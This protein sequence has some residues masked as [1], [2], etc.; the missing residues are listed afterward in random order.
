MLPTAAAEDTAA[1]FMNHIERLPLRFAPQ[2]VGLAVAVEVMLAD[3]REAARHGAE[4]RR[5][6]DRAAVH[7]PHRD[8]AAGIAPQNVALA[9]A[10]KI[11][12]GGQRAGGRVR[13]DGV[14][15]LSI[16]F[17]SGRTQRRS[18]GGSGDRLLD[19]FIAILRGYG[20]SG[21]RIPD[22]PSASPWPLGQFCEG[23]DTDVDSSA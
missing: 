7:Q 14:T 19:S 21:K 9:V 1:P 11:M 3:D 18:E 23:A 12:G 22:R 15:S 6:R 4:A 20:K 2:H 13:R 17:Q 8:I 10:V 16:G 5:L